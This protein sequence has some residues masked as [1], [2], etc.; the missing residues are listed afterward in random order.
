MTA[1]AP[2]DFVY[3][4]IRSADATDADRALMDEL[5][6][7]C[8]RQANHA[9]LERSLGRLRFVSFAWQDERPVGF[10]LADS[11]IVDLPRLPQTSVT[12]GGL[13]CVLP[14][15][16]RRGLFGALMQ[17]AILSG[18]VQQQPAR[19]L[20][21]GRVAHPGA[22]RTLGPP[23]RVVP[24][25]G[26]AP[27]EWQREV[28]RVIA[29]LYGVERFDPETFVCVGGGTPIG[30]PVIEL[31]ATP[32]EWEVFRAVDRDRGDALLGLCW[33]PD[34]PEGW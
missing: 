4:T 12:L 33:R 28:G 22:Y 5:F 1:P 25:P 3:K 8:Y 17:R 20:A 18:D 31:E 19:H 10:G 21:C 6:D 23:E 27:T 15:F 16:R 29:D 14:E 24:R 26:V 7:A 2:S 34:P 13:C 30:Y 32:E 11:L 9:H